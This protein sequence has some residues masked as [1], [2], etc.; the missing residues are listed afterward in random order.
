LWADADQGSDVGKAA[1]SR[2]EC[3]WVRERERERKQERDRKK[4]KEGEREGE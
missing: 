2:G 3:G 4:E 1:G